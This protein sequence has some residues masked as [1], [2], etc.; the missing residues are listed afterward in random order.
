MADPDPRYYTSDELMAGGQTSPDEG[1]RYY[2]TAELTSPQR[3]RRY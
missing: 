3:G 2:T 1:Q